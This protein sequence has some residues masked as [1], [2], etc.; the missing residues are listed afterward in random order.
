MLAEKNQ[1][2]PSAR[3]MQNL[4]RPSSPSLAIRW[5]Q[6]HRRPQMRL[7]KELMSTA[8][9]ADSQN[10]GQKKMDCCFMPLGFMAICYGGKKWLILE[11]QDKSQSDLASPLSEAQHTLRHHLSCCDHRPNIKEKH[12]GSLTWT[13]CLYTFWKKI[14]LLRS[15][16]ELDYRLR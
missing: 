9:I 16:T 1:G 10:Y 4:F 8:E 2:V 12:H 5:L 3:C 11:K 13:L 7:A 14:I 6:P 15:S